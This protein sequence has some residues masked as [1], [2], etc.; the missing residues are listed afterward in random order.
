ME[1]FSLTS[2]IAVEW[3]DIDAA[4][5]VNNVVYLQWVESARVAF[6]LSLNN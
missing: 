1:K 2:E 3:R 6:F 4:H 5:H